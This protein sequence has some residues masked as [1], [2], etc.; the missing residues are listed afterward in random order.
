[1]TLLVLVGKGGI[2]SNGKRQDRCH[3]TLSLKT[4]WQAAGFR[5]KS[6]RWEEGKCQGCLYR[7]SASFVSGKAPGLDSEVIRNHEQL[8]DQK[9]LFIFLKCLI[10][11]KNGHLLP[12][13]TLPIYRCL[14]LLPCPDLE[15]NWVSTA[16]SSQETAIR[17]P[18]RSTR[19]TSSARRPRSLMP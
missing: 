16:W 10:G 4:T 2:S 18:K 13:P 15:P 1:M 3:G 9:S 19:Q 7:T 11:F 14:A 6:P 8:K 12:Y 17:R 5:R